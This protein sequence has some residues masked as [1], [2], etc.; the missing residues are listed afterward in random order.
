MEF[1]SA[2]AQTGYRKSG[3]ITRARAYAR[4]MRV[5]TQMP[6]ARVGCV[7][8]N[9]ARQRGP[10]PCGRRLRTTDESVVDR[11]RRD[12]MMMYE[13]DAGR[14]GGSRGARARAQR[15]ELVSASAHDG[16]VPD[17][18]GRRCRR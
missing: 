1:G 9:T 16:S 7:D 18:D 13:Y 2:R 6:R 12:E 3:W 10:V 15:A 11:I 8:A 14:S 4:D 5:D 17:V